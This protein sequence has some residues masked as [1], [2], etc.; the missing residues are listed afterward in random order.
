VVLVIKTFPNIHNDAEA[1]LAHLRET[2][3][4]HAPVVLINRDMDEVEVGG[5]FA[6][7]D[8]VVC[9]GRGEGF[10]LPLAEALALGTPVIT[11]GHGGQM[12][13]C[14][15]DT[16]WL[17]EYEFAYSR[18]HLGLPSSVW[19]EPDR[20]SL[21]R[22]LLAAFKA[23]AAE[24]QRRGRSGRER[25]LTEFSWAAVAGR[26]QAAVDEVQR[27][28]ARALRLP[29]IGW[30]STWNSR[31]GIAAYSQWLTCE[32]DPERLVV[33]ANRNAEPLQPD[34][35][36]VRRCWTQGFE[37]TLDE[38]HDA[39]RSA[40]VDAIVIQFNFGFFTL[41]ALGRLIARLDDAGIPVY[42]CLHATKDVERPDLVIRLGD[43][44][45]A[46][47]RARRLLVHSVHDL[48]RLKEQGLVDNVTL[49]PHG[50]AAAAATQ[51]ARPRARTRTLASFGY[52]LPHK[53]LPELVGAF[54]LLRQRHPDLRLLMLNA[55]YPAPES[56]AEEARIREQIAKAGL[57]RHVALVTDFLS[58]REVLARLAGADLVVYPYQNTSE[59]SS[60]AV[61]LG[62]SALRPVACTPLPI[63]DDV[64]AVTHRLSGI[65][66][67]EM[68]N[69]IDALLADPAKLDAGTDAQRDWVAAHNWEALSRR[70]DGLV[71]GEF[72]ADLLERRGGEAA[73]RAAPDRP[74]GARKPE[75]VASPASELP[76]LPDLATAMPR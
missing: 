54:A 24:R 37:D 48:N 17:C 33:F 30:V 63:F 4:A 23:P 20:A 57:T 31:C 38:L 43:A 72:V 52:L 11:T 61:R 51:E 44:R 59:S 14:G 64:A 32:I 42:L 1:Q 75:A 62:L 18:N 3:P 6:A 16:G 27:L 8:V 73:W 2:C 74:V 13:F 26:V 46:L 76:S 36:A 9:P 15:A 12:D 56:A 71:R 22:C 7:A 55:L 39:I 29:R 68:A 67:W 41:A 66:S 70:L 34:D 50:L 58:E 65:N 69:D 60:A 25:V 21:A 53:G 19:A 5:L 40:A 49:F 47:S 28:D 35:P 45:E 10:G